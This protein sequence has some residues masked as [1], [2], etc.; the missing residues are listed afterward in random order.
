MLKRQ[1]R[2]L[3]AQGRLP[4]D[5]P[6]RPMKAW[7]L[8]GKRVFLERE[9]ET[10]KRWRKVCV[11]ELTWDAKRGLELQETER[12][13][14]VSCQR[15]QDELRMS[16]FTVDTA[17][18][19]AIQLLKEECWKLNFLHLK[20]ETCQATELTELYGHSETSS[21]ET[22]IE[23]KS[24]KTKYP[25]SVT[26]AA[27]I[28]NTN[29]EASEESPNNSVVDFQDESLALV[30]VEKDAA[31]DGKVKVVKPKGCLKESCKDQLTPTIYDMITEL[32][33]SYFGSTE[34]LPEMCIRGPNVCS[35]VPDVSNAVG[36]VSS[37]TMTTEAAEDLLDTGN[38]LRK[39]VQ[40]STESH[41]EVCN[42]ET[43]LCSGGPEVCRGGPEVCS[44]G[45]EV[46]SGGPE[47]CSGGPEVCSGGPEV[48]NGETELCSGP[49]VCSG[50]PEVCSGGPEVCSGGPEVCSGGPEVC[51]GGP[52]V[53]SGGPEVCS[54]GPE[55]SN[56][57]EE[58]SSDTKTEAAEELR[59]TENVLSKVV[60]SKG[61]LKEG[62]EDQLT[63]DFNDMIAR[64]PK[65]YFGSTESLPEMCSR[66]P[67]VC[68]GGPE[69]CSGG[70]EVCS[71]GPEVSNEV[72][73][74]CSDTMN[75]EAT[76][77]LLKTG[78]GLSKVVLLSTESRPDVCI[79]VPEV[80]SGCPEVFSEVFSEV[81]E[82]PNAVEEVSSDTKTEAAEELRDTE[83][84]LSKV[85][86]SKGWLKEG[87]EDQL[88]KDFNDMIARLPK[89]Y[90]G[91]TE[92][93]P[94]MCSRGPEVCSGGPEVCSGGPEVCSGGPEVCS[95]GPEVS[96]EVEEVCSDTM[97]IE[98]T[99]NLLKTGNGLSKVVLLSTESRPDVCI[100]VPEVYSEVFSEVPEAPNAVEEVSSDTKTEAAEELRD[101]EN[102]L[103]KVVKS[104]GWL[105]EGWEDQLTKDFNDMIARLPKSYFGSN[106]SL[107]EVCSGVP[108][109][110]NAAEVVR[111]DT[112]KQKKNGVLRFFRRVW[113]F[114]T[115]TNS[116]P[117]EE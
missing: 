99:G 36:E 104:K 12:V 24:P 64:L 14:L 63:K 45:P 105:K 101:T 31:G 84:V 109:V 103:S 98:A 3:K 21:K 86:K 43:E 53:C 51:S 44:R 73:E 80:Y 88:T 29:E 68:S 16:D 42:G 89:S 76:G 62:W 46:C 115:C 39:V 17:P 117:K 34:S 59:D 94:E 1:F 18:N 20:D 22:L 111:S 71:G 106:E 47:V 102:V 87:W 15:V 69:V 32:P 93:L 26:G 78:N 8:A 77:N 83:N 67:E 66:G 85:V 37:D 100:R 7:L 97:N 30:S 48:C 57:V 13:L 5:L 6:L 116:L 33:K 35:G 92:S 79:R 54:G 38:V 55:V 90:F 107:P 56:P 2:T 49:E 52:E 58:V 72:E 95:G 108:E 9:T 75:I 114:F 96:N 81:P 50:G 11:A 41:A 19:K 61:W 70:P 25:S 74:V 60:K 27:D 110:S 10:W 4:L 65:S 23:E 113:K 28:D 91:S 40:L 82:A 112:K